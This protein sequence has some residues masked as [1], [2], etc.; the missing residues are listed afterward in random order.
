[1]NRYPL[2]GKP[3]AKDMLF[4]DIDQMSDWLTTPRTPRAR[5]L[6][7]ADDTSNAPLV[8]EKVMS[9]RD[10]ENESD[11]EEEA[12]RVLRSTPTRGKPGRPPTP[13]SKQLALNGHRNNQGRQEPSNNLAGDDYR[14][15][16]AATAKQYDNEDEVTEDDQ[17][18]AAVRSPIVQAIKDFANEALLVCTPPSSPR[19]TSRGLG[20]PGHTPLYSLRDTPSRRALA[21]KLTQPANVGDVQQLARP[22]G[23]GR[24]PKS[25]KTD[26]NLTSVKV[27]QGATSPARFLLNV[28]VSL[29]VLSAVIFLLNYVATNGFQSCLNSSRSKMRDVLMM[30]NRWIFGMDASDFVSELFGTK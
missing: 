7:W 16:A 9:A 8:T 14:Q 10:Y 24:P 20:S 21:F 13:H 15:F 30:V 27:P 1:M 3:E 26:Q 23:R 12:S 22:R 19:R 28:T 11:N 18:R 25:K 29:I 2:R 17:I 6:T 5:R 4:P